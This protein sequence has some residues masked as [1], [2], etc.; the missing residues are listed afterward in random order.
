VTAELDDTIYPEGIKIADREMGDLE[1]Q[2]LARLPRRF[3]LHH[4]P[5]KSILNYACC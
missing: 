5:S 1:T 4:D 2:H 3:E